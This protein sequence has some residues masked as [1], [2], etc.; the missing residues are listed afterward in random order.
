[1]VR[2]SGALTQS[3]CELVACRAPV[4]IASIK[5]PELAM[6]ELSWTLRSKP[7]W[8][9]KYADPEI[10]DKWRQEALEQIALDAAKVSADDDSD[11]GAV[12][13]LTENMVRCISEL[14]TLR[15]QVSFA[16]VDYVL[17][18]LGGYAKIVDAE[19]GIEVCFLSR[20]IPS[21]LTAF[22][23]VAASMPYGTRTDYSPATSSSA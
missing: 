8:Q 4:L 16:Q 6:Y 11:S 1:M 3:Q 21:R 14:G 20:V 7:D 10:R 9:R 23:S 2:V 5:L 13:Y 18:E 22:G 17:A 19:R 12:G 15:A